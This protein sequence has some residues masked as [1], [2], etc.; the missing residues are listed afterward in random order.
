MTEAL[1]TDIPSKKFMCSRTAGLIYC[2]RRA[3]ARV[4]VTGE[5]TARLSWNVG[6]RVFLNI[7]PVTADAAFAALVAAKG[8]Q[9]S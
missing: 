8:G 5:D 4:I 6:T 7:D 3:L 2:D 9:W 1:N